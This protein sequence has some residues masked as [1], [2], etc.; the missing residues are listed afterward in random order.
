MK[1][2]KPLKNSLRLWITASSVV[3]FMGGWAILAHAP[4][5]APLQTVTAATVQESIVSPIPTL[6][7]VPSL[8]EF[9]QLQPLPSFSFST[10]SQMPR[11][12]TRGS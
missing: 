1:S 11:F 8:D 10:Q 9:T 4:K 12:R 3:G 5:P 2:V 6:P 7:P